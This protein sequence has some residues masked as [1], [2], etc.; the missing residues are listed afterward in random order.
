MDQPL[1][2]WGKMSHIELETFTILKSL[3]VKSHPF[4]SPERAD[5]KKFKI[6][7]RIQ[8]FDSWQLETCTL[9]KPLFAK[10]VP[11]S[12]NVNYLGEIYDLE[13]ITLYATS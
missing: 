8:D 7:S 5:L 12:I 10:V 6:P 13:K 1:K 9:P 4:L 11:I 2:D 3:F